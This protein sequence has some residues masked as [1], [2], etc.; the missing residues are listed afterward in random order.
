VKIT[1]GGREFDVSAGADSVTVDGK[2]YAVSIRW[3]DKVPIVTVDGL[4]FRV[5]LPEERGSEMTV[6]VDHRPVSI[7]ATGTPRLRSRRRPTA[8]AAASAAPA[9]G[10]GAVTAGMTGEIVEVHVKPGDQVNE[11]AILVILE[12]MKMRNEVVAPHAGT[13]KTVAVEAGSRVNQG[14]VLVAFEDAD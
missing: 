7:A 3:N 4:P 10:K 11:G 6:V 2:E 5:E 13:V 9:A 8:K 14:D 12:A 1:I